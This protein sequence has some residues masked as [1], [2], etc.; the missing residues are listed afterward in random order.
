M[1]KQQKQPTRLGVPTKPAN[2]RL[3]M[4]G[5]ARRARRLR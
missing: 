4:E 1:G 3:E 5:E 2:P